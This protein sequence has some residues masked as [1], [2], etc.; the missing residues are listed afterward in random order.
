M[1]VKFIGGFDRYLEDELALF[2]VGTIEEAFVK[3][4]YLVIRRKKVDVDES[5]KSTE[6][7][8][9]RSNPCKKKP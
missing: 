5:L 4:V 3:A 9:P 6:Y 8:N 1:L 2:E 7:T